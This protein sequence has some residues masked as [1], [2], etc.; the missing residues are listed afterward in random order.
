[1]QDVLAYNMGI[2]I[3]SNG[4]EYMRTML[5]KDMPIPCYFELAFFT[6][7]DYQERIDVIILQG[8]NELA[9][10]NEHIGDFEIILD[11]NLAMRKAGKCCIMV[12]F[13]VD[14]NHKLTVNAVERKTGKANKFKQNFKPYG[15]SEPRK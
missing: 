6:Q 13:H 4:K 1:M 3:F 5:Q 9:E 14:E 8:M 2:K 10:D 11:E 15:M 12:T 7:Q